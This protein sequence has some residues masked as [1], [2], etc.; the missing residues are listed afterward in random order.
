METL[1]KLVLTTEIPIRWGD[2][3]AYQHVNNTIYFR[4]MEQAR[5]EWL[6]ALGYKVLPMGAAPVVITANCTFLAP[7]TYPGTVEVKLYAGDPG[8]SSVMTWYELRI[9]GD[10]TLYATGESKVV[11]MD[12][13]TGKSA[14]IPDELRTLLAA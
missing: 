1:K 14:P 7:L 9:K 2:M 10:E 5:V 11:W 8:R 12:T 4:Y 3:D 6:E 13:A